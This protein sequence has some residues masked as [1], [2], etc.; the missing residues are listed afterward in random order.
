MNCIHI[1]VWNAKKDRKYGK[2]RSSKRKIVL[3]KISTRRRECNEEMKNL[4]N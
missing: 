2:S 4:F 3:K 1:K